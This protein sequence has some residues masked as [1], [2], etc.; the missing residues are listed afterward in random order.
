MLAAVHE[1]V[2]HV[3]CYEAAREEDPR[4]LVN[5]ADAVDCIRPASHSSAHCRFVRVA[6]QEAVPELD[7]AHAHVAAAGQMARPLPLARPQH[8]EHLGTMT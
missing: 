1:P 3:E 6:G 2:E 5:L 7:A 8:G 4:Y